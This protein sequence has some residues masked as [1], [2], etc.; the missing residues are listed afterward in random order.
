[1]NG[2]LVVFCDKKAIIWDLDNTLYRITPEFADLLDEAMAQALVEDLNVPMNLADCKA[3]VKESY[4]IYRDG[5]E[6]FYRDY[7]I[8]PKDLFEF[9]FNRKPIHLIEPYEGLAEKLKDV[10]F[11]QY[12]FTASN[13]VASAKIL[14]KIGLYDMFKNRFYS[15]EDFGVYKKNENARVYRE[16]CRK[17]GYQPQ[18]CIFVDDSYSNLEFAKETGM[19]T[20]RIYYQTNSAKDKPYIDAA[21]KGIEKCVQALADCPRKKAI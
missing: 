14:Q 8:S 15:V 13:R 1:M 21:F 4:K 6:I 11:D 12:V 2:E 20:I 7:N 19:A 5:G 9:Y 17:I 3:L 16:F 18:E 10:P